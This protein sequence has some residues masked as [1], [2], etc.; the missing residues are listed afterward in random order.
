VKKLV[1]FVSALLFGA[2]LVSAPIG[3]Q[4]TTAKD[5]DKDKDKAAATTDKDKTPAADKD[6]K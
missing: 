1:A 2:I 4:G 5:K 3:C 6:K